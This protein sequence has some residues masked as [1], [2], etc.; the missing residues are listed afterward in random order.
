MLDLENIELIKQMKARYF[1]YLDS[2]DYDG[3]ATIFT[4]DIFAHFKG[5]AYDFALDGW[6][7]LLEFYKMAITPKKFG[8][9]T[10]HHPEIDV[11]GDEATGIWYLTDV[12][13]NLEDKHVIRGSAIYSDEYIKVDGVWK[14]R[15]TGYKRLYEEMSAMDPNVTIMVTPGSMD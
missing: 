9:H 5:G 6:P 10:G 7:Q 4:D 2:V 3:L 13:Y 14:V 15:K 1:R 12:F 8:T 11:N